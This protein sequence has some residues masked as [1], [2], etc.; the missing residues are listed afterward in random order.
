GIGHL[1]GAVLGAA[2]FT[3]LKEMF[4]TE[5]LIGAL[6][7]HWQMTLG[8]TIIAFVALLPKGLMGGR[9]PILQRRRPPRPRAA[10]PTGPM[11]WQNTMRQTTSERT[12]DPHDA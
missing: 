4:Q 1:R 6:A 5:A 8:F 7:A 10:P 3:L 11:E 12:M 9:A 2:L